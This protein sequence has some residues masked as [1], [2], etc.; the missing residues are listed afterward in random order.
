MDSGFGS[1]E[2]DTPAVT[3]DW[4]AQLHETNWFG[5]VNHMGKLSFLT[6]HSEDWQLGFTHKSCSVEKEKH[7]VVTG[8]FKCHLVTYSVYGIYEMRYWGV[9][10]LHY[11]RCIIC[12][13]PRT[14]FFFFLMMIVCLYS[15]VFL[16]KC[17]RRKDFFWF[18]VLLILCIYIRYVLQLYA[19]A[20][21]PCLNVCC[22][23]F[24]ILLI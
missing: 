24:Y 12:H 22:C 3:N 9:A 1:Q 14:L 8:V 21:E 2:A 15:N 11:H 7:E 16:N 13:C 6:R 5:L 4:A 20:I 10:Q 23:F 17:R 19:C 18:S